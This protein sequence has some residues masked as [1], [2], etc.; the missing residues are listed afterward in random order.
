MAIWAFISL[1]KWLVRRT[2]KQVR[3]YFFYALCTYVTT[4]VAVISVSAW[5]LNVTIWE[6]SVAIYGHLWTGVVVL[7]VAVVMMA[8]NVAAFIGCYYQNRA[9]LIMYASVLT[10]GTLM[11]GLVLGLE[12]KLEFGLEFRSILSF[13]LLVFNLKP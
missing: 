1:E 6:N 2:L 8:I 7:L 13:F 9:L 11:L 3:R 5:L 10:A 12:L 4:A